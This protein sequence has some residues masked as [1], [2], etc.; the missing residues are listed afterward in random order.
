M[1]SNSV[2]QLVCEIISYDTPPSCI[3]AN[4]LS[5]AKTTH[6]S[7]TVLHNIPSI[8]YILECR[9]VLLCITKTLATFESAKIPTW[10][11]LFTDGTISQQVTNKNFIIGVPE[12]NGEGFNSIML[13]CSILAKDETS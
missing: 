9:S 12:E 7:S 3:T 6:P 10:E 4:I 11:H 1:W 8:N 13:S 2:T 5:Q